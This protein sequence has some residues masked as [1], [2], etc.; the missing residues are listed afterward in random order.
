M[1]D[2]GLLSRNLGDHFHEISIGIAYQR[3]SIVVA[4]IVRRLN[5]RHAGRYEFG[6]G[7]IDVIRPYDEDHRGSAGCRL[8]AV[9]PS[10]CL[11]GAEADLE[12][13]AQ[14]ELDMAR[15]RPG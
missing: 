1:Q 10:D 14:L 9:H 7:L 13:V 5:H 15:G 8:D 6:V 12:T 4:G 3:I 2:A 11:D